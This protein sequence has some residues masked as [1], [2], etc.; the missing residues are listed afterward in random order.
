MKILYINRDDRPDRRKFQEDQLT[1]LGLEFERIPAT[2]FTEKGGFRF[3]MERGIFWDHLRLWQRIADTGTEYAIFEDDT[4]ITDIDWFHKF[5]LLVK[6]KSDWHAL[7]WYRESGQQDCDITR[8][9]SVATNAYMMN[10]SHAPF[11]ARKLRED[12]YRILESKKSSV[13]YCIDHWCRINYWPKYPAYGT[14][15]IACQKNGL[16]SDTR[17]ADYSWEKHKNG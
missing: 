1:R 3:V 2:M 16:G 12:Y 17:P 11:L 7:F 10:P 4:F 15:N 13:D 5:I 8:V 14:R 6:A 9:C